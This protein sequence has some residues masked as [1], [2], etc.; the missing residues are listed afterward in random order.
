[1]AVADEAEA[2]VG[3]T[4][5]VARPAGPRLMLAG[6][7]GAGAIGAGIGLLATA[8]WLI[9]RASQHPRESA[10]ALG[11]VAVQFFG[12]SKGIL[13]YLQRLVGH[14]AAFRVLAE[15]RVRLYARLEVLSPGG[16]PA[17]R[18]GDLLARF[19]HDVDSLQDLVVRVIPPFLAAVLVG[20]ATVALMWWILPAAGVILLA[21]LLIA[22]V[23]VPWLAARLARRREARQAAARGELTATVVDLIQGAPDLIAYGAV[24]AELR[25]ASTLGREL[26][27]VQ[28]SAARTAGVGQALATLL[29][30]AAMIGALV[31][32]IVALR[33]GRLQGTL[34][35]VLAVVPLACFE[36]TSGLP[37]AA[38]LMPRLR[39]ALGRTL[40]VLDADPPVQE[41]AAPAQLAPGPY[42]VR[43]RGVRTRYQDAGPWALDGIDL[44]LSPGRR[45]AVVGRSGAGK[46]TLA[47]VLLR[48]A[49]YQGG[50]ATLDGIELSALSGDRCRQVIGLVAQDAH[51]FDASLEANLRLARRD[52]TGDQ[53]RDAL[54]RARLLDWVD[55]LPAGLATEVGEHG[56][57]M[58]GG[59]RQRLALARALLADFPVLV[60][61]EPGEHLDT[62]TADAIVA[63]IL[64]QTATRAVLL[65]THRLSGLRDLDEI[66]VLDGGRTVQRGTHDELLANGGAYA[67]MWQRE[68]DVS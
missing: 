65:I 57:R 25:R 19:V 24:D 49:P 59:Q 63:D 6:L 33:A 10:L 16:L 11:I 67:R 45:V 42:V 38:Q 18:H 23:L 15:L 53:L 35:V 31:V 43:L 47:H 13:R 21:A 9:S 64:A 34:L 26:T 56:S 46:S 60:V 41:P 37:A 55:E 48:F 30:G 1:M 5:A 40:E 44:E 32:G 61:D 50:S 54:R 17:A 62:D 20:G 52:A 36:L 4:L 58:S 51:V 12:L 27:D 8:A 22:T 39:R 14:D 7:L 2:T 68:A 66:I 28:R 3:E 29:P